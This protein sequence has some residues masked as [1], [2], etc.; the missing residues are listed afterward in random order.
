MAIHEAVAWHAVQ[1]L[2]FGTWALIGVATL[3]LLFSTRRM[4]REMLQ[5]RVFNNHDRLYRALLSLGA[6]S[7]AGLLAPAPAL[8]SVDPPLYWLVAWTSAWSVAIWHGM[9]TLI[10][11]FRVPTRSALAVA[12]A[13]GR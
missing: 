9:G 3:W 2:F 6:G 10:A 12:E 5:L 8:L 4:P 13:T 7:F 11:M 1:I